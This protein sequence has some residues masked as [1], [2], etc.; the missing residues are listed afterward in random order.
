MLG[1][2]TEHAYPTNL[3]AISLLK[4]K[5]RGAFCVNKKFQ[6]SIA[7]VVTDEFIAL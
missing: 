4:A 5:S 3:K 2:F 6:A 1:N 7:A